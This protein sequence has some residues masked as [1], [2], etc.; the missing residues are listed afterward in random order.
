[1]KQPAYTFTKL[2][3]DQAASTPNNLCFRSGD[4]TRAYTVTQLANIDEDL[5]SNP[6]AQYWEAPLRDTWGRIAGEF[7]PK[8]R[9][10]ANRGCVDFILIHHEEIAAAKT[11]AEKRNAPKIHLVAA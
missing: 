2:T 4:L 8:R 1:M 9:A 3:F 11:F 10:E 6:A 7:D 5:K